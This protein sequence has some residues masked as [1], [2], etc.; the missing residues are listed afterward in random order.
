M[1]N[2]TSVVV[3]KISDNIRTRHIYII[4]LGFQRK[5]SMNHSVVETSGDVFQ[6]NLYRCS[7]QC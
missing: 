5:I 2:V 1:T 6:S 4:Q 3:L 7:P